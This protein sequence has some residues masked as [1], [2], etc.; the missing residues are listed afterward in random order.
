MDTLRTFLNSKSL[1]D[2]GEFARKCGTSI[3]YLRKAISIGQRLSEALAM[4]IERH[5]NGAVTVEELRPDLME[6]WAYIRG[7]SKREAA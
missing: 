3:G 7:T 6:H 4:A 2:Q 1:N 5:S